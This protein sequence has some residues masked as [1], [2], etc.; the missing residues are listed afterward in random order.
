[1]KHVKITMGEGA[2]DSARNLAER[3]GPASSISSVLRRALGLLE[4]RWQ[5][6][7]NDENAINA[8]R[9]AMAE[10][11]CPARKGDAAR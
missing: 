6:L 8:E 2:L 10:Y 9:V 5:S 4:S 1:M 7:G 3:Y 11:L